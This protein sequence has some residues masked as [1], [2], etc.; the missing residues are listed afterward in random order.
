MYIKR[1]SLFLFVF[2]ILSC[3][4]YSLL[5]KIGPQD[6]MDYFMFKAGNIWEFSAKTI[7][8][9]GDT[10]NSLLR[11]IMIENPKFKNAQYFSFVYSS[12]NDGDLE[13]SFETNYN[14][15]FIKSAYG[16]RNAI[17][18]L[19]EFSTNTT[20]AVGYPEYLTFPFIKFPFVEGLSNNFTADQVISNYP[21][22]QAVSPRPVNIHIDG[23]MI[24]EQNNL[25]LEVMGTEYTR[26]IKVKYSY[27]M[28]ITSLIDNLPYAAGDSIFY[29][30]EDSQ[31][32]LAPN[33]GIIR[34]TRLRSKRNELNQFSEWY[35][36]AELLKF[37]PTM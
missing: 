17:N 32:Y 11:L 1:F 31:Y 15:A 16:Y 33:T 20:G 36:N 3:G 23:S 29:A 25:T 30:K 14:S 24:I 9:P 35:L 26:C 4:N 12:S 6:D 5:E 22:S 34:I 21:L 7:E 10:K 2:F 13:F 18:L 28:E 8:T 27:I 37:S 19:N